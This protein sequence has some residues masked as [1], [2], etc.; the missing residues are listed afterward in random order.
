MQQHKSLGFW[1]LTA[2]VVGNMIGSGVFLLP[3]ALAHL[4]TISV[5]S[6]MLTGVGAIL[7]SLVFARLST[8]FPKTGG[9]YVYCREGFGDFV[10]FQVAYNYWIYM[11]VG[12]A[13]IAVALTGYLSTFFPILSQNNFSA[14]MATAAVVWFLTIVN[15]IG[16]KLAGMF[17]LILTILKFI[18]LV[19]LGIIGIFFIDLQNLAQ[20]NV[21]S[22]SDFSALSKGAML[23][24]WAFLGMESAS[25]PADEVE[26]PKKNIPRATILG[27]AFTALLYIIT[28]IAI[29]G[30]IPVERLQGSNAPFA[31]FAKVLFG[32]VGALIIGVVAIISCA[33]A[34][35]GWIML[36]AQIPRAAAK[37][38]L[39]PFRFSKLSKNRTP[40]FGLIVS[41]TLVTV[42]LVMNFQKSLVDQFTFIISLA[43]LAALVAYLYTTIA[44]FLICLKSKEGKKKLQ[45]S[46]VIAGLAFIYVFWA[47]L[48]SGQEIIYFGSILLFTS[49]PVYAWVH[50]QKGEPS[51]RQ[52][53]KKNG[54]EL[55]K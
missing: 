53:L 37:D 2:L 34:L 52:I 18:P 9:P 12:N 29:M 48:S 11:W 21:S 19:L 5:F 35:N 46:L 50:W 43:T 8:L 7:L 47:T 41:S 38:L 30:V 45:K 23:T 10:G 17:Q 54:K 13:A 20:F 1:M 6:W 28:T 14:F 27:T 4:G 42:L 25:I 39:F 15:I 22:Q 55:A 33:G 51:E 26:N 44:E 32:D 16:V 24:L 31:D 49:I 36:Q 40:I 3:S